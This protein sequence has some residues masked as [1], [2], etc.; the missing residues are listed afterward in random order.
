MTE[1]W[2]PVGDGEIEVSDLGRVR[3]YVKPT[4]HTHGYLQVKVRATNYYVHRLICEAFHGTPPLF[5]EVHH[6]DGNKQ[7]NTPANLEWVTHQK[8]IEEMSKLGIG[9]IAQKGEKNP[10]AKLKP[11]DV[12]E[13]FRL[14]NQGMK[15]KDIAKRFGVSGGHVS[16]ILKGKCW[17]HL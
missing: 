4:V 14:K 7:N 1:A 5:K 11:E 16:S 6:R 13:I 3:Y 9:C 8:N 10:H 2:Q 17:G 15:G 12:G